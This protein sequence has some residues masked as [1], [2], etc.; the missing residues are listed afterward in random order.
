MEFSKYQSQRDIV[1]AVQFTYSDVGSRQIYTSEYGEFVITV[2][3]SQRPNVDMFVIVEHDGLEIHCGAVTQCD[4]LII[5]G[6]DT[7][8]VVSDFVFKQLFYVE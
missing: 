8:V 4:W 7:V 1:N 2:D 5:T 6:S 3:R